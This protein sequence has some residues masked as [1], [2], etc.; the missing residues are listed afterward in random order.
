MSTKTS[1]IQTKDHADST[2]KSAGDA[3]YVR[4]QFPFVVEVSNQAEW[5]DTWGT[6][7]ASASVQ[8]RREIWDSGGT[9]WEDW[10]G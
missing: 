5:E 2:G 8:G 6:T 1:I 9:I 10:S 3:N 7:D 4:I